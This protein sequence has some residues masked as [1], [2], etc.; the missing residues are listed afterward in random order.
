MKN[1]QDAIRYL[2]YVRKHVSAKDYETFKD[3]IKEM[4]A[5]KDSPFVSSAS[6]LFKHYSV[7][8]NLMQR[9]LDFAKDTMYADLL[10]QTILEW[11]AIDGLLLL[12]SRSTL[13]CA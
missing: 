6:E 9:L 13:E 5:N 11:D 2:N 4:V 12:K 1:R 8:I 7:R 3:I 10:K